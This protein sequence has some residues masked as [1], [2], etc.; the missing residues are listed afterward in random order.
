MCLKRSTVNR[1]YLVYP[2]FAQFPIIL[3]CWYVNSHVF[4]VVPDTLTLGSIRDQSLVAS[5]RESAKYA[6]IVLS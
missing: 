5:F 4:T 3:Q 1:R 2:D 6:S